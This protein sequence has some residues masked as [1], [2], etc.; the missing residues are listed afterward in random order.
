M[1]KRLLSLVSRLFL[2]RLLSPQV[3]AEMPA[4][5]LRAIPLGMYLPLRRGVVRLRRGSLLRSLCVLVLKV[6]AKSYRGR[7]FRLVPEIRP[8]DA[9]ELSFCPVDSMVMDAVYWFGIQGY[10]GKV[11]EIWTDMCRNANA[12][13]EIGG[14]VGLFTV[15][16]GRATS[17]SY[18]VVEPVP[19]IAAVL[20]ENL[21]CN[22]IT[23]VEVLQAAAIPATVPA[24]VM[25]NVPDEGRDAPVGSHLTEGVEVQERSSANRIRVTG[26]PFRDLIAGRDLV[27]IDAEGIEAQ[28]LLAAKD[29]IL[30]TRPSL[31]V[32]VLP[33]ATRLGE[34]ISSLAREA[35][36]TISVIPE[37][38]S[39]TV[40]S[41]DPA[42][43][44]SAVPSRY[45]SKDIL[46]ST[47]W[48]ACRT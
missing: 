24:D 40:V 27:K 29:L 10:E 1:T 3:K 20:R 21:A 13:L 32:E 45:N 43:F 22:G 33:E 34:L 26:Q 16:G 42:A 31:L 14:N 23:R 2:V 17:G 28:L 7:L 48:A 9:P 4:S 41:I 15:I 36:Y 11:A 39:D 12:I 6:A 5:L 8:L 44:S 46:L 30:A 25:L 37:F 47:H 38:G 18:L 35:D 19:A